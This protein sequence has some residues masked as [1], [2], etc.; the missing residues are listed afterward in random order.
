MIN[1]PHKNK[2]LLIGARILSGF[3]WLYA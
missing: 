3:I 2:T 1:M